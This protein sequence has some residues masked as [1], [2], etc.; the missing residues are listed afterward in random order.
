V[1][2]ALVGS[3]ARDEAREGSDMGILVE[4]DQTMRLSVFDYAGLK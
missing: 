3:R 4:L 2:A 1:H